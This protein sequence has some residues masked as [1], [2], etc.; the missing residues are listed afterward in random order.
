VALHNFMLVLAAASI[1]PSLLRL[2][3]V[4][5]L[6]LTLAALMFL[7]SWPGYVVVTLYGIAGVW[8]LMGANWERLQG[9]FPARIHS[10]FPIGIGVSSAAIALAISAVAALVLGGATSTI[11]LGGYFWGSGGATGRS[12]P[13]A[14]RGVWDGDQLVAAK[15]RAASFGAVESELFLDSDMPSLYDMFNDLYG[16]P[17]KKKNS[18]QMAVALASNPTGAKEQRTAESNQAGREFSALRNPG[19][20]SAPGRWLR[21]GDPD[22]TANPGVGVCASP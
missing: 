19:A 15:E 2:S 11:A 9:A 17:Q 7:T 5:S 6:F 18:T 1:W 8:W 14:A 12:D 16:E 10:A 22:R 20:G 4:L 21:R 3:C 13:F